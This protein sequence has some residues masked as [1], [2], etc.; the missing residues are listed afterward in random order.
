MKCKLLVCVFILSFQFTHSQKKK[1][2]LDEY[3]KQ[4]T[5]KEFNNFDNSHLKYLK[6]SYEND[7]AKI[8]KIER[9]EL[10]GKLDEEKYHAIIR[11]LAKKDSKIVDS[12]KTIIINYYP[13]ADQCNSTGNN[14]YL[15]NLYKD[16]L[17]DV[18][19]LK[20]VNQYFFYKSDDGLD[21]FKELNWLSDDKKIME[22]LFFP[23]HYPCHSYAIIF[24]KGG[25]YV[26]KGEYY[27]P[28]ILNKL[29]SPELSK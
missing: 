16:Y 3:S 9:R 28:E 23:L 18:D 7:T 17:K 2:Y 24:P 25:F 22:L 19:A 6:L 29:K 1:Y 15:M 12:T 10:R 27:L 21:F 13:G 4:I 26:Y 14:Y 11:F 20:N 5:K 8:N